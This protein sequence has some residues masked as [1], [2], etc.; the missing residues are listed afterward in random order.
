MMIEGT[1]KSH[2]HQQKILSTKVENLW[3]TAL[4]N[5]IDNT[6]N[7]VPTNKKSEKGAKLKQPVPPA[8]DKNKWKVDVQELISKAICAIVFPKYST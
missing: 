5:G 6:F 4:L 1:V 7:P 3:S 8:Y 2:N